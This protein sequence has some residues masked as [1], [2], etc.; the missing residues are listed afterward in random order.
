MERDFCLMRWRWPEDLSEFSDRYFWILFSR[1]FRRRLNAACQQRSFLGRVDRTLSGNHFKTTCYADSS[2]PMGTVETATGSNLVEHM[3]RAAV[4]LAGSFGFPAATLILWTVWSLRQ[5][6]LA[7][8]L[9]V[10]A[11]AVAFIA[12]QFSLRLRRSLVLYTAGPVFVVTTVA[13][14]APIDSL[15]PPTPWL[16]FL[17]LSSALA[18]G[19][20]LTLLLFRTLITLGTATRILLIITGA[21]VSA[22]LV[23]AVPASI[24]S[25][26]HGYTSWY[27]LVP[28][29]RLTVDGTPN[30]GYV[31][32][33]SAGAF[34]KDVV[35]TR[36]RFGRVE[37][38]S[39]MMPTG[40]NTSV[41]RSS[42]VASRIPVFAVGDVLPSA[43]VT[44]DDGPR[45]APPERHLKAGPTFVEFTADDGKRVRAEW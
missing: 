23:L 6:R 18:S 41:R 3:H 26:S 14:S 39:V 24:Y 25:A 9:I 10:L 34:G 21:M 27:F 44:F 33:S 42:T 1:S 19:L 22:F 8:S 29:V 36:R 2:R 15:G 20:V 12:A 37:A 31:H 16:M 13:L 5:N 7:V 28:A 40:Q 30:C 45:S 32:L 43:T 11:V 38:Y 17:F 35:V 4:V